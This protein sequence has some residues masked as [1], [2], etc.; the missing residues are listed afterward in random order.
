M[1]WHEFDDKANRLAN[2]LLDR[3]LY[4][5]QKVGILLMNCLEWLP[6]YFGVL[7]IIYI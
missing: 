5:G 7:K 6:I 4:K 1:T 3:G 2:F